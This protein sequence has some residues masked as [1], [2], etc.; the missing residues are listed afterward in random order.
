MISETFRTARVLIVDDEQPMVRVLEQLLERGGYT[1]LRST[2]DPREAL[3]CYVEFRPDLILLDL[4]MP[5]LSGLQALEQ[6]KR[7]TTPEAFLPV[8]ILTADAQPETKRH[9][10]AAGASDFVT[11][12]FD[13]IE[14]LLRV[15]NLLEMRFLHAELRRQNEGLEAKVQERTHQLLEAEKLATMGNLLAGVAHELNGPL[16]VILGHVALFTDTA[17]T[18]SARARARDIGEA[19]ER[20]V[21]IVRSFLTMA[22]RHPPERGHVSVNH[23]LRDAVE[24][25]GYELRVTNVSVYLDL[26]EDVPIVWAD[27]HQLQ[28][29]AV[30]LIANAHQAMRDAPQPRRLSLVTRHGGPGLRVRIEIGDTGPGVPE[31]LQVRIFEPF[32]TTKAEGEGTGLGLALSRGI[33]EGHGGLIRVEGRPGEGARFVIELPVGSPP[34]VVNDPA[35]FEAGPPVPGKTI[36]VVDDEPAVAS[37]LAEALSRDGYRVD[38]AA[39]GAVA[40]KKLEAGSYDL[41]ISDSG[42]PV[43]SGPDLY[44]EVTRLTPSL[45]RRFVFVTGDILNPRTREFLDRVGVPRL[46]KPFTIE[47]VKRVVRRVL[48]TETGA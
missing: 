42:M 33:V 22:R 20:C 47:T 34:S 15:R 28:Q 7:E 32:F 30:N 48:L 46:E 40:L 11:K 13:Q 3:A 38:T 1:N 8:L 21:R 5:H 36:L 6:L 26:D 23:V 41:I 25:L 31:E 16:S 27:R 37:I 18:D 10:L 12:P 35:T 4:R 14:L 45:A 2:T 29:V 17:P 43:L 44:R 39:N 24:L 19:A 9:A